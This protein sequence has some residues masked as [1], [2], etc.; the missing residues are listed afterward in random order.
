[1][2]GKSQDTNLEDPVKSKPRPNGTHEQDELFEFRDVFCQ[3]SVFYPLLI[4]LAL[5]FLFQFSG[6]GAITFYTALIFREAQCPLT[7]NDCALI[8]GVTYFVSSILGLIL[9]KH[10]GRRALLLISEFGMALSQIS[11]GVYFYML[12]S[13]NL[14]LK[15]H[16][17]DVTLM[18]TSTTSAVNST[19]YAPSGTPDGYSTSNFNKEYDWLTW[20]PIPT[21][22]IFTIAFNIGMGSLTWI[23]AAEISPVRSRKFTLTVANMTSN[24]WWFLV[25]KTFKNLYVDFGPHVPFFLYGSI[26]ILGFVFIYIF[27]PETQNITAEGRDEAFRGIEP[28][29]RRV[30]AG[31]CNSGSRGSNIARSNSLQCLE[32]QPLTDNSP[33]PSNTTP[34]KQQN[35]V[36]RS[37]MSS[38]TSESVHA[39]YP[40]R[41][42]R[43][44]S[45]SSPNLQ[46]VHPSH[47]KN[48][49]SMSSNDSPSMNGRNKDIDYPNK[50]KDINCTKTAAASGS[51][52]YSEDPN[53]KCS[54]HRENMD[55][56]ELIT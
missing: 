24:F 40:M 18:T 19:F 33:S 52:N 36:S 5:M 15:T 16:V 6:Q 55:R 34:L 20:I 43:K 7:P 10:F 38:K 28:I 29:I 45:S 32:Q 9:K 51:L 1:M 27:L 54:S 56:K 49:S 22:I 47:H 42:L 8:I 13:S 14:I 41:P 25:T 26:C 2:D 21:L 23:V 53:T 31:M 12:N 4:A 35:H 17:K 11:L 3:Q 37:S 50:T 30:T 39:M 44:P 48:F 46:H